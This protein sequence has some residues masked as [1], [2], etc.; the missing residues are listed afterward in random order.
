MYDVVIILNGGMIMEKK[1]VK[2]IGMVCSLIGLVVALFGKVKYDS[3]D[4]MYG[5]ASYFGKNKTSDLWEGYMS[6]YKIVIIVGLIILLVGIIVLI[7]GY[8]ISNKENIS[9]SNITNSSDKLIDLQKM[10]DSGLI[11]QDEYDEKRKSVL[12]SF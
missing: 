5:T 4:S 12:D 7:S 8:M 9:T 11:T 1:N 10:L 6:N 3:A 2:V